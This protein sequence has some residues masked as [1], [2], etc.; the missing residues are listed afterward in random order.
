MKS[1]SESRR[2]AVMSAPSTRSLDM[3]TKAG[4]VDMKRKPGKVEEP[5]IQK[6]PAGTKQVMQDVFLFDAGKME[7]LSRA[8]AMVEAKA[9][10]FKLGPMRNTLVKLAQAIREA[11]K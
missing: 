10:Q 7:G 5:V 6:M 3:S 1:K 2:L 8:A 4:N 9:K 11:G